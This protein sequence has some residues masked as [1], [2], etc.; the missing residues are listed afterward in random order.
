MNLF[1]Q[2]KY[3]LFFN[4]LGQLI[5]AITAISYLFI[6]T[7]KIQFRENSIQN[8]KELNRV[9][10]YSIEAALL[11]DQSEDIK[12]FLNTFAD[13]ENIEGIWIIQN[14]KN[15][16]FFSKDS[17]EKNPPTF[18]DVI[19]TNS[20]IYAS[21]PVVSENE[22]IAQIITKINLNQLNANVTQ[23]TKQ[24]FLISFGIILLVGVL[25][26]MGQRSIT[27]PI[28]DLAKV[29]RQIHRGNFRERSKI[30]AKGELKDLEI[31]F[32][33]MVSKIILEKEIA[34]EA[35]KARNHFFSGI[36]KKTKSF[37]HVLHNTVLNIIKEGQTHPNF[38]ENLDNIYET[39]GNYLAYI[40][41]VMQITSPFG[42]GIKFI[43]KVNHLTK[44][45]E[46]CFKT[47]KQKLTQEH[48]AFSYSNT[49]TS[50]AF[51]DASR[52]EYL[53]GSIIEKILLGKEVQ[54]LRLEAFEL[55]GKI[56][57]C[58]RFESS[59]RLLEYFLEL[60][61]GISF[62]TLQE[63]L[64]KGFGYEEL[65]MAE[66]I[67]NY[68]GLLEFEKQENNRVLVLSFP[69]E[70]FK[71]TTA[72]QNSI[73]YRLLKNKRILVIEPDEANWAIIQ[74]I[75]TD[76]ECNIIRGINLN[77]LRGYVKY[78]AGKFDIILTEL[79]IKG[80]HKLE[81]FR[82]ILHTPERP[83]IIAC[84]SNSEELAFERSLA[85]GFD[86]FL[87]KPFEDKTLL[88]MLHKVLAGK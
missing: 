25:I 87:S 69:L 37:N 56:K 62:K 27:K 35:F 5:I 88:I 4:S 83:P 76:A 7:Q 19:F 82:P 10:E 51:I 36:H 81:D 77:Q 12:N 61:D 47:W 59:E 32:N 17:L 64:I 86:E 63:R 80:A 16:A 15:I 2:I 78:S 30:T 13:N 34:V 74:R 26:F 1:N 3:R 22:T 18:D 21:T 41:D 53:L 23:L 14:K 40:D 46:Q 31:A 11:F 84:T 29:A 44:V 60:I 52:F 43:D 49:T 79:D 71:R 54:N 38:P 8:L 42:K 70:R 20:A 68:Q 75:L 57:V 85:I 55:E 6:Y 50:E 65:I 48:I 24:I 39:S 73:N 58:F 33:N 9:L 67:Q 72:P 28:T 66:I 45:I